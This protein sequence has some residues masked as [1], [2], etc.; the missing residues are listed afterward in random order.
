MTE[1]ETWLSSFLVFFF[2]G[3]LSS[4]VMDG[5]GRKGLW[6]WCC[7]VFGKGEEEGKEME[8]ERQREG[9]APPQKRRGV[10]K[11]YSNYSS[12]RFD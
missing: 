11:K 12:F 4:A 1:E 3:S 8:R 5:R 7:R 10:S 6:Y 9:N 2:F